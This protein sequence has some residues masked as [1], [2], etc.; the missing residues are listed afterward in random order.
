MSTLYFGPVN[1]AG[2]TV[3]EKAAQ[4]TIQ[5]SALGVTGYAGILERG[6]IG[7]LIYCYS[8]EDLIT[9]TGGYIEDSVLPN[10]C[11]DFFDMGQG[12]GAL[13]LQRLTAGDETKATLTF[14]DRTAARQAVVRVDAKNGGGWGGRRQVFVLSMDEAD[15]S[16]PAFDITSETTIRLPA[17]FTCKKD[18]FKGG[19]V[20][21]KESDTTY[22]IISNTESLTGATQATLTLSAESTAETDFGGSAGDAELIVEVAN[23]DVY[24]RGKHLAVEIRN[25]VQNPSTEFGLFCY[26]DGALV[27]K[28]EDLSMDEDSDNYFVPIINE[29]TS[30]HYI[31]V[32]NLFTGTPTA[33]NRPANFYAKSL[34]KASIGAKTITF[35]SAMFIVEKYGAAGVGT[36]D[37]TIASFTFG[38]ECVRDK[39]RITTS[40]S[41][42]PVL[43]VTSRDRMQHHTFAAITDTVAYVA[44]NKKSFGFTYTTAT[45]VTNEYTDV[46]CLA[47]IPSELKNGKIY[48]ESES[49]ANAQGYLIDAN[50][51]STVSIASGDLTLGDTLASTVDVRLE[52]KQQLEGG[53]D[54]IANLDVDD[55]L[56]VW[57]I[58]N[59]QFNKLRGGGFGQVRLGNPNITADLSDSNAV[60]V[61]KAGAAYARSRAYQYRYEVKNSVTDE[62]SAKT[63]VHDTLGKDMFT[64][65]IFPSFVKVSDPLRPRRQKTVPNMGMVHGREAM[66][67]RNFGG[68]HKV[69]AGEGVTLS[70]VVDLPTGDRQLNGEILN[71][72]GI[73][74]VRKHKGQYIIWGARIPSENTR[75][76]FC[77]HR[78]LMNHYIN[79]LAESFDFIVFA[80]NDAQE[81]ILLRPVFNIY[82]DAEFKK[83]AIKGDSLQDAIQL[84]IDGENNTA[85]TEAAGEMNASLELRLADTVEKFNITVSK[86]G[87]REAI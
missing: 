49:G 13:I 17:A 9:K 68:Y 25:G 2:V 85:A 50:T 60:L 54:G 80:I 3:R 82:F 22:K 43:A 66:V 53:Y 46:T 44:D 5:Q 35:G 41:S 70:T 61:Q 31:T 58:A 59:S 64:K 1:D 67:A 27:K 28:W 20:Y 63:Y 55:Y 40:N 11:R 8:K 32:T 76:I 42:G 4:P 29:D 38:S 65:V 81:R 18:Q 57:D 19:T 23:T 52:Y 16:D 69:A 6:P 78:E 73:Q 21:V 39:L 84:K 74:Y 87:I 47:F 7:E 33:A 48:L 62:V 24:G 79:V 12:A 86:A 51:V 34:A 26:L 37:N 45:P 36:N 71:P 14:Y 30:N 15:P 56:A 72:A 10:V 77:Q 75:Y 83:R